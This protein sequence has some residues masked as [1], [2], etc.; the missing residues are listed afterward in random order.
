MWLRK[1]I[2]ASN[3]ATV[4]MIQLCRKRSNCFVPGCMV[5]LKSAP[6]KM[7]HSGAENKERFFCGFASSSVA[8]C[9]HP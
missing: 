3:T 8:I 9:G 2:T 7:L 6:R 5:A 4:L 1:M